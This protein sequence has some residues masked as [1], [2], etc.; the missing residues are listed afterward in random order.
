[1]NM[2]K[3]SFFVFLAILILTGS[4]FMGYK[5]GEIAHKEIIN[6]QDVIQTFKNKGITFKSETSLYPKEYKVEDTE[7]SIYKDSQGN[8]LYIYTFG[9]FVERERNFIDYQSENPSLITLDEK[10]YISKH[11]K[12]KNLQ[13]VYT[14]AYPSKEK[15]QAII[16]YLK[17]VDQIIFSDLNDGEEL[18]LSAESPS[19]EVK[20]S[21]RYYQ[22]WWTNSENRLHYESYATDAITLTYKGQIP[23]QKTIPIEYSV[24]HRSGGS[25]SS[26]KITPEMLT[27][28]IDLGVDNCAIPREGDKYEVK[29]TLDGKTEEVELKVKEMVASSPN[30]R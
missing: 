21:I 14:I 25:T 28:V 4:V 5:A 19:W 2:K 30:K 11:Y 15:S 7:P 13:L 29:I 3:N 27:R 17:R 12:A 1:M 10:I 20:N 22:H 6:A 9:S 16:D 26:D 18:V 8:L 23:V 24:S